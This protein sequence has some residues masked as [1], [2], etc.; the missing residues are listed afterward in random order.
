MHPIDEHSSSLFPAE[1]RH[2]STPRALPLQLAV[3]TADLLEKNMFDKN[4]ID[5]IATVVGL[6]TTV[7]TAFAG[8]AILGR[9]RLQEKLDIAQADI[10]Y[11]MAVEVAHCAK[12]KELSRASFKLRIRKEVN[13]SGLTWSGRFTPGRVR[14]NLGGRALSTTI[15]ARVIVLMKL[16]LRA[17]L[18][19]SAYLVKNLPRWCDIALVT[20]ENGVAKTLIARLASVRS[21]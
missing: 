3:P 2:L 15:G 5:L 11:L 8:Q 19:T 14:S 9:K 10:A 16:C 1:L 18:Y 13:A 6:L 20:V 12:N 17:V 7:F 4:D 21:T